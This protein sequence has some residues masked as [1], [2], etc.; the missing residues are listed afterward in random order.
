MVRS[1]TAGSLGTLTDSHVTRCGTSVSGYQH[2]DYADSLRE[3]GLPHF[4]PASGGWVLKR[5]IPGYPYQ[6]AM[7]CYP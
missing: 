6:D 7:G 1:S 3:F 5:A 2:L 4:L